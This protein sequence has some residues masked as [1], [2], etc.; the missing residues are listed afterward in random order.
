MNFPWIKTSKQALSVLLMLLLCGAPQLLAQNTQNPPPPF[1]PL[2]QRADQPTSPPA[3][4]PA[5]PA[6]QPS[7]QPPQHA[8]Q[9]D[10]APAAPAQPSDPQSQGRSAQPSQGQGVEVDP[11]K[12]PLQPVPAAEQ[13]LPNAPSSTQTAPQAAQSQPEPQPQAQPAP[14]KNP[15]PQG[16]AVAGESKTAGGPASKPAGTAI[17]PAKQRQVRSMLIKLG[18]IA[19]GGAAIGTVYALTRSTSSTPPNAATPG[20]VQAH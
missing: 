4:Q 12:G 3:T 15:E 10:Q 17:A 6:A 20:A 7:T 9:P 11:S 16:T 14:K 5:Q 1:Q 19:A 18:L 8:D 2:P 13:P